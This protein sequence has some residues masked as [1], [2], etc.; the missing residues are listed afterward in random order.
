MKSTSAL[1]CLRAAVLGLCVWTGLP[2]IAHAQSGTNLS[3]GA[4]VDGSSKA[5]GTSYG[6]AIDGN[7]GTY[8]S[9]AGSTG[10]VSVKWGSATTGVRHPG[11]GGVPRGGP[12]YFG[13]GGGLAGAATLAGDSAG[14]RQY[15]SGSG[16]VTGRRYQ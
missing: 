5:S 2:L 8:W 6:N 13:S 12:G 7:I 4:S 1:R 11:G 9:P 14:R 16:V 10:R 3:L 15:A